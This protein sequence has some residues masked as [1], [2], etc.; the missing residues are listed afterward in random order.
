MILWFITYHSWWRYAIL[1]PL[2]L[3][4]F[5]FWEA[6]QDGYSNVDAFGNYKVFPLVLLSIILLL[7]LSRIV[8]RHSRSLDIYEQI[9]HEI[10]SL[11]NKLG[12][13]RSRVGDYRNRFDKIRNK[14]DSSKDTNLKELMLLKQELQNK[15]IS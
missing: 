4:L 11:I 12:V 9:T 5:Q 3:Y 8:R 15:V 6:I 1:S 14:Q 13:E 2:I 10:N 7:A